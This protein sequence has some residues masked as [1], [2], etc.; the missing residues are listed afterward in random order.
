MIDETSL[1]AI[2]DLLR[3]CPDLVEGKTTGTA[4]DD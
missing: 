2:R 1:W 4:R 3:A